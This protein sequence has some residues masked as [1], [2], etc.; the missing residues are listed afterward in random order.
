MFVCA[1]FFFIEM[2]VNEYEMNT[3]LRLSHF[4]GINFLVLENEFYVY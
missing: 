3:E 4:Y 1:Q 2:H